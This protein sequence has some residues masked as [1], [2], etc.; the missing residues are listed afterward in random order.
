MA[1]PLYYYYSLIKEVDR[2][3]EQ[4]A[5]GLWVITRKQHL[6]RHFLSCCVLRMDDDKEF[7]RGALVILLSKRE[8]LETFVERRIYGGW[9]EW[10]WTGLVVPW[11][12]KSDSNYIIIK[13]KERSPPM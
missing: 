11:M 6:I 4:N 3:E 13:S 1:V 9:F 2:G 12:V 5:C 7:Q 10:S 8:T